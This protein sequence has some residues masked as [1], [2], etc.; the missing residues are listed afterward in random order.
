[1]QSKTKLRMIF[2]LTLLVCALVSIGTSAQSVSTRTER[3]SGNSEWVM[4]TSENG[5][6]LQVR[7]KGTVEFTEDYSDIKTLAPNSSVRV[8]DSRGAQV[9]RLEME[10]DGSGNLK[11]SYFVNDSLQA[12]DADGRQWMATVMLEM[13]RQGGFDAERRVARLLSQGGVNAVFR[14]IALIKGD[15]GKSLYFRYLLKS[16]SL[17][18]STIQR[19]VQQ[20]A[21]EI[22][23]AYEKRQAL[24]AV[25][26]K[27][28][29]D[30]LVLNELIAAIGTVDSDYERGQMLAVFLQGNTLTHSQLQAALSVITGIG[31]DYEKAQALLRIAKSQKLTN[32]SLPQL[33]AAIKGIGSDYEQ[34]RVLLALLKDDSSDAE[35]MRL[36]IKTSADIDSDY[37]QARVLLRVAVL[38]KNNEE[39]R[40]LLIEASR[41]IG[42]E[43]ERGRV[44]AATVR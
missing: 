33:F 3:N 40:K 37:E 36:V 28:L 27:Y 43:Y 14:E 39:I 6:G 25:S 44:L 34:A 26:E 10:A 1:M 41:K 29:H 18:T 24:S 5:R 19:A 11:R 32:A 9:R 13:V 4:S 2:T 16:S 30:P 35:M 20:I 23:S 8:R 38:N 17:D 22:T 15:Y 7:I 12:F 42:S 31:S 21:R